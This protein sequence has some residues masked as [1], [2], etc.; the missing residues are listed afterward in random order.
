[1]F[2]SSK[3]TALPVFSI[4]LKMYTL[5]SVACNVAIA[6]TWLSDY[7]DNRLGGFEPEQ[8]DDIDEG[9]AMRL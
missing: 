7:V 1:M 8:T 6:D 3:M 4:P 9:Q 2:L 5:T